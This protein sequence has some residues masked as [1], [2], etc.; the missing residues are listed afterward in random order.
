[1]SSALAAA[2]PLREDLIRRQNTLARFGEFALRSEDLDD[3][4]D[5]ACRLVA[6]ALG[7]SR[8]KV[9]E[10][11]RQGDCA[12]VRAGVGWAPGVVGHERIPLSEKSSEAFAIHACAP[13]VVHDIAEESRFQV[14]DFMARAG[15]VSFVN[16]PIILP[17]GGAFGLLQVDADEPRAF[18]EDAVAFLRTYAT[19]LGP[20][21]DRLGQVRRLQVVEQ[22]NLL[23][24]HEH[25]HRMAND[26]AVIQG[27]IR[28]RIRTA[29]SAVAAELAVL[30]ER[31]E[32]LRV[33]HRHLGAEDNGPL[34]ALRPYLHEL[35]DNL[36]QLRAIEGDDIRFEVIDSEVLVTREVA[37]AIG[38]IVNE[39]VTN[40]FKYAF[41]ARK[42]L[43]RVVIEPVASGRATLR[44]SDDGIGLPAQTPRAGRHAGMGLIELLARQI[45]GSA[46]WWSDGGTRLETGFATCSIAK[47]SGR[48]AA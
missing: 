38:L 16:V 11:E 24:L 8:A 40:S 18:G 13:V 9:L 25:R 21:I 14:P 30:Q 42:G 35:I 31:L 15:V 7:T 47:V 32:T 34:I 4:L 36:R 3:V 10:I 28:A 41:H 45:G 29:T 22:R 43:I 44:L 39:F 19:I 37:A 1:M 17:G 33:L 46:S 12:L 26:L 2:S 48:T 27:L 6:D 5:A 23:L 20:V